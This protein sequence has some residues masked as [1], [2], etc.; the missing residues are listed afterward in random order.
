MR[1]GAYLGLA[2]LINVRCEGEEGEGER[3]CVYDRQPDE[4]GTGGCFYVCV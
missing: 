3:V 4:E 1:P 2:C